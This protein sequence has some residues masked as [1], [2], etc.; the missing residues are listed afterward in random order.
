MNDLRVCEYCGWSTNAAERVCCKAG[1]DV[2]SLR[3]RVAQLEQE[4]VKRDKS[5]MEKAKDIWM[6][7]SLAAESENASL[8]NDSLSYKL[9]RDQALNDGKADKE[10]LDHME[11]H[12][13]SQFCIFP[14]DFR[15]W[16]CWSS[17][18]KENG[19]P[20]LRSAIDADR[21]KPQVHLC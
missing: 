20:D 10:R 11:E 21:Q 13:C 17:H 19:F 15:K 4:D 16:F 18:V 2:D 5:I 1:Q 12:G 7:R 6:R 8:R 9:Q 14:T 3:A